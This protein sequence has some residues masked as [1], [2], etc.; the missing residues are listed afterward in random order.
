MQ[1]HTRPLDCPLLKGNQAATPKAIQ[2][3]KM[4]HKIIKGHTRPWKGRTRSFKYY[5]L[6]PTRPQ[7]Q[8]AKK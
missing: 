2:D 1:G 8:M 6:G 5:M 3:P 4:T 7:M